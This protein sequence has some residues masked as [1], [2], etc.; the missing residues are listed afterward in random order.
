M[1]WSS[2]NLDT[3]DGGAGLESGGRH[4]DNSKASSGANTDGQHNGPGEVGATLLGYLMKLFAGAS[5]KCCRCL[6]ADG[7]LETMPMKWGG[8]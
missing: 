8:Y 1:L 4:A 3:G 6:V 2:W 5:I 7:G